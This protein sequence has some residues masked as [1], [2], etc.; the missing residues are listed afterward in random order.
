M[1]C[2]S[3]MADKNHIWRWRAEQNKRQRVFAFRKKLGFVLWGLLCSDF[4]FQLIGWKLL[5]IS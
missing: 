2:V 5:T 4:S 3:A 1:C